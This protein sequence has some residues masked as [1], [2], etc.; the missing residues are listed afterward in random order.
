MSKRITKFQLNQIENALNTKI[1]DRLFEKYPSISSLSREDQ[2]LFIYNLLKSKKFKVIKDYKKRMY[3]DIEHFI[4]LSEW[5]KKE[6]AH[7]KTIQEQ[8][9]KRQKYEQELTEKKEQFLLEVALLG[10]EHILDK[11]ENF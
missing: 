5:K 7:E 6:E 9:S 3:P 2:A 10:A 11:L 1:N 4:D 8:N